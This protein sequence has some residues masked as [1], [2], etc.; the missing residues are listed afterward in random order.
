MSE[1][2]SSDHKKSRLSRLRNPLNP[3][4]SHFKLAIIRW[5]DIKRKIFATGV[6]DMARNV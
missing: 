3:R 6:Q 4:K 2:S 1:N 5:D